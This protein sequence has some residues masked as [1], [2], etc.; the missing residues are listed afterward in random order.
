MQ[1]TC[2]QFAVLANTTHYNVM[3]LVTDSAVK[4]HT[5]AVSTHSR[6]TVRTSMTIISKTV[7]VSATTS[8]KYQVNQSVFTSLSLSVVLTAIFQASPIRRACPLVGPGLT[9]IN[10]WIIGQLN[11]TLKSVSSQAWFLVHGSL[12]GKTPAPFTRRR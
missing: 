2:N 1:S 6:A 4:C 3:S 12:S 10:L 5:G 9:C 11:T 7:S 8:L